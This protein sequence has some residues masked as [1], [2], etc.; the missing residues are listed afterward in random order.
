MI[1]AFAEFEKALIVERVQAG[2][3]RAQAAGTHC[4]RPRKALDLR[5]A[6]L[7]LAQGHALHQVVEML[8]VQRSTLRRKLAEIR[9]PDCA[10]IAADKPPTLVSGVSKRDAG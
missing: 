2:V 6:R 8:G 10:R 9:A 1:G 3:A 4:G 7:L 5:A